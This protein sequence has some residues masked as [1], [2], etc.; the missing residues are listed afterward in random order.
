MIVRKYVIPILAVAGVV[1][2]VKTVLSE[3]KPVVPAPP[4]A[5]PATSAYA[6]AV[7]G[8]GIVEASTQ[9]I[10]VGAHLP[11]VVMRVLAKVG[12]EVKAGDA[13]FVVDDRTAR[14]EVRVREA[15]LLSAKQSLLKLESQPR[16]E[17]VPPAEARVREM[18]AMV[19]EMTSQLKR[20]ESLADPRAVS[21]EEVSRRK[22]ALDDSRAKLDQMTADL[23]LLKAG[24]W[25]PDVEVARAQVD[26]ATAQVEAAKTEVERLT[27][28]A[29]VDGQILQVNVRPGEF[30]QAGAMAVPL[31]LLGAT[32]TLH[33]RVDIDENDA[34]RIRPEAKAHGSLR[35]NK[36]LKTDLAFV[37]IEPYV[38][39]KRSLT[40]DGAER[41]D[42]RVLQV[43][44]AFPRAA[45]PVYVGQQMDVFIEAPMAG[46]KN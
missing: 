15:A 27:V 22:Y 7:A 13:L 30:A 18:E 34:W 25:K 36:D 11:G 43:L 8:A 45:L 41:V 19:S 5:A 31:M 42:T 37:R 28:K 35:G 39:P 1:F 40:G 46:G 38:V 10:A 29:P 9:N 32:Q 20:V 3:N 16:P 14:A 44:Y 17:E 33:V 2:A 21:P 24:A 4:V 23:G 12:D 26:A 6:Q